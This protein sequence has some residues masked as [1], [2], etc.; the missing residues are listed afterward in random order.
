[1]T[2]LIEMIRLTECGI[3]VGN[4]FRR[5]KVSDVRGW[6]LDLC[7]G[8]WRERRTKGHRCWEMQWNPWRFLL[9][10]SVFSGK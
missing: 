9:V 6:T 3:G 5:K 1:M 2:K 7:R 8:N 10:V 4:E